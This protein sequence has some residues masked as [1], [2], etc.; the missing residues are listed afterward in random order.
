MSSRPVST[1]MQ[2]ITTPNDWTWPVLIRG[3]MSGASETSTS[4]DSLR[5]YWIVGVSGGVWPF[6]PFLLAL[7]FFRGLWQSTF[8]V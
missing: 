1:N 6:L 2:N 7:L 4:V 8:W 3:S 5:S